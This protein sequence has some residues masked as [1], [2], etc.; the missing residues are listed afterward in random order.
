MVIIKPKMMAIG[1]FITQKCDASIHPI[2]K[3][4]DF[5]YEYTE[6]DNFFK[7]HF[8]LEWFY[9]EVVAYI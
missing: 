6:L 2:G 1:K 8:V 4:V 7:R 9:E 3:K 5:I